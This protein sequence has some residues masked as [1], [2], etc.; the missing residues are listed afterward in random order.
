MLTSL[1]KCFKCTDDQVTHQPVDIDR[2]EDTSRSQFVTPD[3]S[4]GYIPDY[5]SSSS[6]DPDADSAV[7]D[8]FLGCSA[9]KTGSILA[10]PT[11]AINVIKC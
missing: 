3:T 2:Y 10:L 8:P 1:Q 4:N 9:D 7:S 6:T 5:W 11:L